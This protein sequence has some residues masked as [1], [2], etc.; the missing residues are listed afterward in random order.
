MTTK[1]R[2]Y[3]SQLFGLLVIDLILFAGTNAQKVPSIILAVGLI[4]LALTFYLLVY[5]A[6]TA[7]KVYG[8][9]VKRKRRLTVYLT[10][11]VSGLLA[12]QSIGELSGGELVLLLPL[13]VLGIFYSS[14]NAGVR[15]KLVS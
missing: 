14:Y 7:A 5:G 13:F 4:A 8:I 12:W 2:H 9:Q 15:R 11:L 1:T 6:L 3:F 10:L